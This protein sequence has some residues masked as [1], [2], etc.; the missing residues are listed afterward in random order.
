MRDLTIDEKK[1]LQRISKLPT[2]KK[3][4][5][6][7]FVDWRTTKKYRRSRT[8]MMLHLNKFLEVFEIVHHKDYNKQN[9]SIENLEVLNSYQHSSK[10]HSQFGKKPLN[11]KPVNAF[12]DEKIQKIISLCKERTKVNYQSVANELGISGQTVRK[13]Y[14][15]Y[16]EGLDESDNQTD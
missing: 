10:H 2:C 5:Y 11:W 16:L 13:Y 3:N 8:F 15:H 14:L 12:D 6:I 1:E 9:D 4:G 7:C